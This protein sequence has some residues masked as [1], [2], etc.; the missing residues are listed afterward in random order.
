M[1][2]HQ[3]PE[4]H[5][6]QQSIFYYSDL[7]GREDP[8]LRARRDYFAQLYPHMLI[9]DVALGIMPIGGHAEKKPF[10]VFVTPPDP[11]AEKLIA[12]AIARRDY[13][14]DF[15]DAVCDFFHDCAQTIMAFGEAVYEIV[16][17]SQPDDGTIVGFELMFIQPRT[18]IRRRGKLVQYVPAD[19]A[20]ERKVPQYVQ[21]SPERILT[22]KPPAYVQGKLSHIMESLAFLSRPPLPNFAL[23][24]EGGSSKPV[25]YDSAAHIRVEKLAL[26]DVGKLIGWN[27]RGLLQEETLEYYW[28]YRELL[29]ERFKIELRGSIL[30]TLNDGLDRAGRKVGFSVRLEIEGLP[31]L[32]DVD[33][34]QAHLAAGDRPFK[35]IL[36]PFL[37]F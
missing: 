16:Y 7:A 24:G 26:A 14:R 29:F 13:S 5:R 9:E 32:A 3:K 10:R 15:A 6:S 2:R 17:L 23:Q 37:G 21:L 8:V 20:R 19:V 18:V 1:K 28:L 12:V 11:R 30:K 34:A 36:E 4:L 25:P 33:A 22:F 35:E 27:A 31:T